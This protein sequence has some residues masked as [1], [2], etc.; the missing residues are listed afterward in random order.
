LFQAVAMSCFLHPR[1]F[2][3]PAS[4]PWLRL[5]ETFFD[6]SFPISELG[7]VQAGLAHNWVARLETFCRARRANAQ[8]ILSMVPQLQEVCPTSI[9]MAGNGPRLPIF[10]A[11]DATREA[12]ITTSCQRGLG[13]ALTYPD[14]VDGIP[15]FHQAPWHGSFPQARRLSRETVTLPIHPLLAATDLERIINLLQRYW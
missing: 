4:L 3:I 1:L 12:L 7:G 2:W 9:E 15:Y 5:G 11:D 10:V 14:A 13:L 6:L 8:V